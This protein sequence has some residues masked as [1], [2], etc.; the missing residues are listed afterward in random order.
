MLKA[1]ILF[2]RQAAAQLEAGASLEQVTRLPVVDALARM[3]YIPDEEAF[4]K[5][6]EDIREAL[7]EE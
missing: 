7:A 3:R 2:Y 4:E 5:L 1:N 6:L